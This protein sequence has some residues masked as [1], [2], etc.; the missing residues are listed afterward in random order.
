MIKTGDYIRYTT[1]NDIGRLDFEN[2]VNWIYIRW[3]NDQHGYLKLE[4]I[5]RGINEK[6]FI[7]YPINSEKDLLAFKLKF[8]V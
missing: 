8:G 4:D 2:S 1:D 3:V 5:E 6:Y 7:H